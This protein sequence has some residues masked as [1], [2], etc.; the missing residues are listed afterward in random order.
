M[1][2]KLSEIRQSHSQARSGLTD[3]SAKYDMILKEQKA[4]LA[5]KRAMFKPSVGPN[6]DSQIENP[7]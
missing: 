7:V 1:Q 6:Q 4:E 2:Q 5:K 3:H